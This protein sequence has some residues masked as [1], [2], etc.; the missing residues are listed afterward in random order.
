MNISLIG[1]RGVGKTTL[2]KRIS[3]HLGMKF[4]DS[5]LYI[6]S[7]F[8]K[9]KEIFQEKGEKEFRKIEKKVLKDILDSSDNSV[10]SH[11][12]GIIL[13]KKNIF[14]IKSCSKVFFLN[15]TT[16]TILE[17]IKNDTENNRPTLTEMPLE[18]EVLFT[19]K[20]RIPFYR[21]C[22]D[23]IVDL[24]DSSVDSNVQILLKAHSDLEDVFKLRTIRYNSKQLNSYNILIQRGLFHSIANDLDIGNRYLIITDSTVCKLYAEDLKHSFIKNG[25]ECSVISFPAGEKN[26]NLSTFS[27]LHEKIGMS[28]DRK[29]CIIALGGGVTGDIAGFVSSTYMRGIPFV[30]IPTSLLAMV[31]SSIGGKLGVNSQRG[32]NSIGLFNNPSK[33]FIDPLLLSTLPEIYLRDGLAEAIK[34]ALISDE[35]YFA[36][37]VENKDKFFSLNST[38]LIKLI[39]DSIKIKT[40]IV[41]KDEKESGYRQILNFGHTIGH[42]LQETNEYGNISHGYA[43]TIGSVV[44]SFI[45]LSR[46]LIDKSVFK[47]IKETYTQLGLPSSLQELKLKVDPEKVYSFIKYDKKNV[48]D[49]TNFILLKGIGQAII[50]D[51]VTYQE[52][53]EGLNHVS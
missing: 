28:L 47:T 5:D 10:V 1:Y 23:A 12:G 30:Q 32:K 25:K 14:R 35:T 45:S 2:G 41:E 38:A 24:Y 26:K 7:N 49:R 9:I 42:A 8:G 43:I 31:D 27:S 50:K 22:A 29:S 44:A 15:L 6:E 51:D 20:K 13:D 52:V 33:V 36:Y 53:M 4:I 21:Q 16:E 40:S 18:E 17:R 11:G 37:I 46:G 48:S 39:H 34:H 3:T 19:L